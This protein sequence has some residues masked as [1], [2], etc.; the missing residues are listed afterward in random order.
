[1]DTRT[2]IAALLKQLLYTAKYI[3]ADVIV[4]SDFEFIYYFCTY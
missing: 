3:M 4:I 1:M 2:Q